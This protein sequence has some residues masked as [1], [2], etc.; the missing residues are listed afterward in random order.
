MAKDI[1]DKTVSEKRDIRIPVFEG[2]KFI[3]TVKVTLVT[4]T[5]GTAKLF[6]DKDELAE[7][8]EAKNGN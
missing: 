1:N 7:I 4:Y 6:D 2:R 5:D 8:G 3:G